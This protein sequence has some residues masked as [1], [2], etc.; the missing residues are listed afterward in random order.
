MCLILRYVC[1]DGVSEL[2][3]LQ[4][5]SL[6][7][8]GDLSGAGDLALGGGG[9]F[10]QAVMSAAAYSVDPLAD[11]ASADDQKLSQPFGQGQVGS[12]RYNAMFVNGGSSA[13]F[14]NPGLYGDRFE[15]PST[16][17]AWSP[18]KDL[19]NSDLRLVCTSY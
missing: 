6:S 13:T 12:S 7:M 15:M 11:F 9:L 4:Q 8:M 16:N 5:S 19:S 2:A 10:G 18:G 14:M 3:V 1:I 17:Q